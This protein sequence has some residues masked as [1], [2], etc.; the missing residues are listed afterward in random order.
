M[1]SNTITSPRRDWRGLLGR[2][3]LWVGIVLCVPLVVLGLTGSILVFED[4]LRT[5]FEASGHPGASGAPRPVADIVAAATRAAPAG[6]RPTLYRAPQEAGDDAI[7]RLQ[8]ASHAAARSRGMIV[9]VDPVSLAVAHGRSGTDPLRWLAALHANMLLQNPTGRPLVGWLG[10]AML[11]LGATGV[12]NWWPRP[13]RWRA[14]FTIRRGARGLL[15]NRELHG[16]VGIWSLV[17]FM[18]VSFSGVYLAFPQAIRAGIDMVT[19]VRDLRGMINGVRVTPRE[20]A[21]PLGID[22]AIAVARAGAPDRIV[23]FVTLPARPDQPYRVSLVEPGQANGTPTVTAIVD[24]WTGTVAQM[25]DPR[26][27]GGIAKFF[28]WQRALHAGAGLG[29]V[30]K[31]LVCL[32]G[33][34]PLLFVIT[35]IRIWWLKRSY[36]VRADT[37]SAS[38]PLGTLIPSNRSEK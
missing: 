8:P 24:P 12:V 38:T 31:I 34:L 21:A 1:T 22:Q 23:R 18:A 29:W 17:V 33:L 9:R 13:R 26:D 3:H 28:A 16:A 4:E 10:V 14:A 6:F 15:L 35:G 19:P 37:H 2:L 25:I 32:S 11:M 36:R 5:L 27:L 20:G 7:V 30:W